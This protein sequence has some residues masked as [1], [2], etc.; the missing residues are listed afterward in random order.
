MTDE[1]N[2]R[3]TSSTSIDIF[4]LRLRREATSVSAGPLIRTHSR[5]W[6]A[7]TSIRV[8]FVERPSKVVSQCLFGRLVAGRGART[9]IHVPR[10]RVDQPYLCI[11]FWHKNA[12]AHVDIDDRRGRAFFARMRR[13][14]PWG[15]TTHMNMQVGEGGS[16]S[17][18][19][20]YNEARM[21]LGGGSC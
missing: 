21:R 12:F 4:L 10:I 13:H 14:A 18:G 2:S 20:C 19:G 3:D 8:L 17:Q 6:M 9:G 15:H 1:P 7:R 16:W 11:R 5:L